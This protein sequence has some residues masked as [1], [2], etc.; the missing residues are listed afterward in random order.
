MKYRGH[1]D[2]SGHRAEASS[3]HY[4]ECQRAAA[5][6]NQQIN[7]CMNCSKLLLKL[8]ANPPKM[9]KFLMIWSAIWK[10]LNELRSPYT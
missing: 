9:H 1:L 4:V 8:K 3:T 2:S 6:N 5:M 10:F 7:A